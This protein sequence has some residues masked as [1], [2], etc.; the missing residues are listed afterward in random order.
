MCVNSFKFRHVYYT[1]IQSIRDPTWDLFRLTI[2]PPSVE[3]VSINQYWK[4]IL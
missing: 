3:I 1:V 2:G 4:E